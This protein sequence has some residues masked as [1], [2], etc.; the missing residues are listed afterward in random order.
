MDLAKYYVHV[1]FTNH[2]H[3]TCCWKLVNQTKGDFKDYKVLYSET[4]S[5]NKDTLETYTD[6]STASYTITEFD[7]L[8][9][10][11][12]W[13][14]VTDTLGLSSIGTGMTNDID[15]PPTQI[16][17]SSVTNNL[18]EIIIT[19]EQSNDTDFVS[20]ELLY[21][22]TQSG[23]Q[24]SIT[25]ITDINTTSYTISDFNLLEERWYWIMVTDYWNLTS[26]SN[27]YMVL[28]NP[29]TSSVLYPIIYDEG[30]QISWSQ[31][32]DDDFQSYKLY[33]SLSENMSNNILIYE[34]GD[35]TDTTFFKIL[36]NLR[37]Y[38]VITEDVWGL[39][40]TSNIEVGD[41]EVELWGNP[42][43]VSRTDTLRL[44]SLGLDGVI[45]S[46]IGD[47]INLNHLSLYG[48]QLT[49]SIPSEIGYL[50]NLTILKLG[51]N[52][53]TGSIPSEI[54]NLTNLESMYLSNNQ[55]TGEIPIEICNL[56]V[57]LMVLLERFN[58]TINQLCPPYPS[59]IEDYMGEQDTSDCD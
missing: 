32:N 4:E 44:D 59:C 7:P 16:D 51:R 53:L 5:G 14:Q 42:Y 30:F 10:N 41:Y 8:I 12:F 54:G 15:I 49:G 36:Q 55:L 25:T 29:T 52:Q 17:V 34:T 22:E 18:N 31:N 35:R 39:Q 46:E 58:I 3:L 45:P 40:S 48:N 13:V 9:E 43:S 33:E 21:S 26:L 20:Y 50:T 47:L 23:E 38:Q 56:N 37:Y 1:N 27:G 28:D 2:N 6:I 24:T 11:W 57:E 19:W